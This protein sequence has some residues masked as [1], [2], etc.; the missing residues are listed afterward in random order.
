MMSAAV[1][2]GLEFVSVM[3]EHSELLGLDL[4]EV[5]R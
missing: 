2:S 1:S 5:A 4:L 3:R